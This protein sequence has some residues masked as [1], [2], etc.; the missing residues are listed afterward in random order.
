MSD[1]RSNNDDAVKDHGLF[2]TLRVG[3]GQD[4][5]PTLMAALCELEVHPFFDRLDDSAFTRAAAWWLSR[6]ENGGCNR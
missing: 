5:E 1:P 4:L 3:D 2:L 6:C